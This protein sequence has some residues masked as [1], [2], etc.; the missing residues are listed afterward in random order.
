MQAYIHWHNVMEYIAMNV[1]IIASTICC[2]WYVYGF[3]FHL[4]LALL[5]ILKMSEN[6]LST[7]ILFVK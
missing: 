4:K 1:I 5:Q 3:H 7:I 6:T 2:F